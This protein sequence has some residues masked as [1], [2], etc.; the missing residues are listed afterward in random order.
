LSLPATAEV[1]ENL[2]MKHGIRI[3]AVDLSGL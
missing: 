2:G 1:V 3:V